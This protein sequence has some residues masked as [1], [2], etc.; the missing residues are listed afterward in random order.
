MKRKFQFPLAVIFASCFLF[1]NN[2]S[3]TVFNFSDTWVNWNGETTGQYAD[4]HSLGDEHGTPQ[5]HSMDV[6][7]EDG[8]LTQVDLFLHTSTDYQDFN[9]LFINTSWNGEKNT[10]EA[11][12]YLVHDGGKNHEETTTGK[13]ARDGLYGVQA[14]QYEYTYVKGKNRIGNP[15][16]IDADD[17]SKIKKFGATFIDINGNEDVTAMLRYNFTGLDYLNDG[18]GLAVTDGFFVAYAPWCA[19]DVIGGGAAPVPEPATMLLFGTGLIGLAGVR[20]RRKKK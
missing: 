16:G 9:S 18:K 20:A 12:D 6:T 7:V 17:L 8:F 3:A 5:L 11:W 4:G 14:D 1:A 19:N 15:N 2:V 13:V 10:F